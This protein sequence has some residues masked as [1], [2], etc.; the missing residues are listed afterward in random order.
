LFTTRELQMMVGLLALMLVSA[1]T[2]SRVPPISADSMTPSIVIAIERLQVLTPIAGAT[3]QIENP[4]PPASGAS[5]TDSTLRLVWSQPDTVV[6]K[7]RVLV[8]YSDWYGRRLAIHRTL[9]WAMIPLFA[10]SY[11]TGDRLARDGRIGSPAWVRTLHPYAATGASVVFG[12]NTVTG[13]WNLWDARHDPEGRVRRVIHSVLFIAA[14]AG[15]AYAGSLGKQARDNSEIRN[16]HRAIALYSM[17]AS[18][19]SM[20]IMLLGGK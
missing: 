8:E 18:Y 3:S 9:S 13:L 6:K 2:A 11:Y 14:D 12:V 1:D 5:I 15:F 17:G 7:K 16:K 19:V 20:M 4:A 10:A